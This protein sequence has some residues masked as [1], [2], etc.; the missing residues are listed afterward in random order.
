ML[1]RLRPGLV[2]CLN[3]RCVAQATRSA[4]PVGVAS[5]ASSGKLLNEVGQFYQD[6]VYRGRNGRLLPIRDLKTLF[7]LCRSPEHIKYAVLGVEM[8]QKKGQDFSEE[9]S[10]L[11]VK[12]CIKLNSPMTA[13]DLFLKVNRRI[14]AWQSPSS[15]DRLV[16]SVL[17]ETPDA[18]KHTTAL[19]N[20]LGVLQYKGVTLS[21]DVV[22]KV[23]A[24]AN[25]KNDSVL[26]KRMVQVVKGLRHRDSSELD[27][28]LQ[29]NPQMVANQAEKTG[30]LVDSG[31]CA[32]SENDVEGE[33]VTE[34][35]EHSETEEKV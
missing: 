17:T 8:F 32:D 3:V 23:A 21:T 22:K 1:N 18:G 25:E 10:G 19:V 11:F 28:I 13:V 16:D 5:G 12:T 33:S 6:M 30:G 15:V 2:R 29:Q 24:L 7:G 20:M 31:D 26:N 27:E 35:G 4:E 34:E 9:T 14:A